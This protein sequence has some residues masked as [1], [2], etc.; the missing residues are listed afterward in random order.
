MK[1]IW[2]SFLSVVFLACQQGNTQEKVE[3]KTQ[4]DSISYAIGMDIGKN[5]GRQSIEVTPA[6]L[7]RG[8]HDAIDSSSKP[9][10]TEEQMMECLTNFQR[11]LVS[12]QME[13]NK[14]AGEENK[15]KGDA[16]L[17]EYKKQQG[18]LSTQS[19]LLYKVIKAGTGA[20]PKASS[21]VSVNY[22]GTLIDGT[23]FDS[24]FKYGQPAEFH[25]NEVISG[26][27]EALMMM[28]TGSKWEVVIPADLAYGVSGK[29]AVIPPNATLIFELE[30]LSIVQ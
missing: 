18:V 24:S 29:G 17:A 6:A 5:L 7:A 28:P 25:L 10:L 4:K 8:I 16:F 3:L 22:R 21:K 11:Q 20:K 1:W 2:A 19:G 30:L 9:M 15:K 12:R 13:K 27:T 26:W 23:E 14:V